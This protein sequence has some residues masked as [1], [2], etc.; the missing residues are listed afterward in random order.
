MLR[1]IKDMGD[2]TIGA[3]DGIIGPVRDFYFDD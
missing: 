3:T 1:S 2:G